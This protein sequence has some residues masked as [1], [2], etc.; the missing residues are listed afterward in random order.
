MV[1]SNQNA[2][3]RSENIKGSGRARVLLDIMAFFA[4]QRGGSVIGRGRAGMPLFTQVRALCT[5]ESS[6]QEVH[7]VHVGEH[8]HYQS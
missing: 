1:Y 5:S 3:N 7:P 6:R 4:N 2:E 8:G